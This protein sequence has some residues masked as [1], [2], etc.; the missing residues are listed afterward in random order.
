LSHEEV[1][2]DR[3]WD[4]MMTDQ[5]FIVRRERERPQ[6]CK[7]TAL[8]K[9]EEKTGVRLLEFDFRYKES[10]DCRLRKKHSMLNV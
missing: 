7:N 3:D 6:Y 5:E 10:D 2:E 4:H 9:T 1:V 8:L